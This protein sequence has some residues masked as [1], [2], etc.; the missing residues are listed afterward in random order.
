MAMAREV[1]RE[2]NRKLTHRC[3]ML[4]QI[5]QAIVNGEW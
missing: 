2:F 1:E 4:C 5:Q 3:T